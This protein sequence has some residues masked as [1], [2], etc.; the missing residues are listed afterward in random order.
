[1]SASQ[2]AS[3]T[4]MSAEVPKLVPKVE[5]FNTT[6]LNIGLRVTLILVVAAAII[7]QF[8]E[9]R[10]LR[11]ELR[12]ANNKML[13]EMQNTQAS[14][15][16]SYDEDLIFLKLLHLRPNLDHKLGWTIAA[17]ISENARAFDR[18]PDFI[19]A[20]MSRESHFDPEAISPAGA[21]G[22]MQI[23]P[24]WMKIVGKEEDLTDPAVNVRRGL[25]IYTFYEKEFGNNTE[26]A[27]TAYNRGSGPVWKDLVDRRDFK[28]NGYADKVLKTY[29]KLKKLSK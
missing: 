8:I 17:I 10:S 26:K 21:V 12:T 20:I 29:N 1:M 18:D 24:E 7:T 4:Q 2:I 5:R 16:A 22:L 13:A 15:R 19:L 28:R 14:V 11:N 27:L 23:M 6:T 25:Q 9:G 3:T